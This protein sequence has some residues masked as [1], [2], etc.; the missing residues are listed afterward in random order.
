MLWSMLV[1]TDVWDLSITGLTSAVSTASVM[2][3]M[4][5]LFLCVM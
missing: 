3:G 5:E 1:K 4:E 2:E